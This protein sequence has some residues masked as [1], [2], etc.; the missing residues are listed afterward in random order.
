M[1]EIHQNGHSCFLSVLFFKI[2]T[3]K[4]ITQFNN[5]GENKYLFNPGEMRYNISPL[6]LMVLKN[7]NVPNFDETREID[8]MGFDFCFHCQPAELDGH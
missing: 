6:K 3:L 7:A 1:V 4:Y 8:E 2:S 5:Q